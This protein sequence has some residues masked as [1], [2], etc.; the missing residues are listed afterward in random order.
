MQTTEFRELRDAV[1]RARLEKHADLEPGFL[2]AVI[3][4]EERFPEDDQAALAEIRTKLDTIL[5]AISEGE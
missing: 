4:A 3:S 2:E 5:L 1:E